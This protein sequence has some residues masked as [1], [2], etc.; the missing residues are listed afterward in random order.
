MNLVP[1]FL[2]GYDGKYIDVSDADDDGVGCSQHIF[3]SLL[4]INI[5]FG[6]N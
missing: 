1:S 3:L 2:R 5:T 6:V 4:Q